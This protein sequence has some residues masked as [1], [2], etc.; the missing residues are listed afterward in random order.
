MSF[1]TFFFFFAEQK[2]EEK[3]RKKTNFQKNDLGFLQNS[4]NVFMKNEGKIQG[5]EVF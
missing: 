5:T 3:V 1:R 2:K 4:K